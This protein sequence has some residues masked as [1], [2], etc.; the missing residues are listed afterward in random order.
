[1]GATTLLTIIENDDKDT[2]LIP[3]LTVIVIPL[4]V[5][6]SVL[7]GVPLM[8]PLAVL[9]FAHGGRLVTLKVSGSPS[10]SLA[11]GTKL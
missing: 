6:T 2:L 3:S 1:M 7:P 9:K 4:L 11:V 10:A 5:P 8:A